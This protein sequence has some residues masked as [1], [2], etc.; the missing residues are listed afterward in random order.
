[1]KVKALLVEFYL[2]HILP[3]RKWKHKI[4]VVFVY[5]VVASYFF[6]VFIILAEP[7]GTS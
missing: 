4:I 1:M 5:E 2:L 7:V 3:K 6:V